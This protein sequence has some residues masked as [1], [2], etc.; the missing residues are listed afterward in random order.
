MAE[1]G[2]PF[3]LMTRKTSQMIATPLLSSPPSTV[4]PSVRRISPS[5]IGTMPSPGTTVSIWAE[6]SSGWLAGDGAG[7]LG[8]QIADVAADHFAGVIDRYLGAEFFH[9]AFQAHGDVIFAAR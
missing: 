4:V 5:R 6:S 3:S 7:K 2:R 8:D 1:Q 9:L